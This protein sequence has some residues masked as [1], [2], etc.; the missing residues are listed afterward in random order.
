M[1]TEMMLRQYHAHTG[2]LPNNDHYKRI[3]NNTVDVFSGEGFAQPTRYRMIK[4]KWSYVSGP[5]SD[6]VPVLPV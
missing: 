5:K 4:G 1:N 6:S 3:G 2:T